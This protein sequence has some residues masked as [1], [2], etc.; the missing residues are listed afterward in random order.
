MTEQ[1]RRQRTAQMTRPDILTEGKAAEGLGF[2]LPDPLLDWAPSGGPGPTIA[3]R[4]RELGDGSG[5]AGLGRRLM[6][7]FLQAA[8]RFPQPPAAVIFYS[9]AVLLTLS[10]SQVLDSLKSLAGAGAELLICRASLLDLAE[11]RQP[12]V[13]RAAG[14]PE[15]AE[16]MRQARQVL[17]P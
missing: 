4:S 1:N 8:C 16:R 15:L 10:D 13:G 7:E 2:I 14:W 12:A 6:A 17:W 5:S 9:G 3:L 11:G